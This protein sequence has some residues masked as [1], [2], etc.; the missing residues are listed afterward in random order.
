MN[1]SELS[2]SDLVKYNEELV[3]KYLKEQ[4][5]N[6]TKITGNRDKTKYEIS[7]NNEHY[8]IK[9]MG[10]RYNPNARGNYAWVK[11]QNFDLNEYHFLFFV[12]YYNDKVHILKIPVD[13]FK[14]CCRDNNAFKNHDYWNGKSA[15]EYGISMDGTIDELLK[16]QVAE[17]C[18]NFSLCNN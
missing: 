6:F 13:V 7:A 14:N 11:K 9:I 12:L 10:Y 3:F 16:Y 17:S 1:I 4:N 5:Y 8:T 2:K 15:P 18:N